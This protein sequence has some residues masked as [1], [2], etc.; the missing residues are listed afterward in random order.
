LL[1]ASE[2]RRLILNLT[3]GIAAKGQ[4]LKGFCPSKERGEG[5]S[6]DPVF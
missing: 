6:T 2:S 4:K 1:K 5:E 3:A